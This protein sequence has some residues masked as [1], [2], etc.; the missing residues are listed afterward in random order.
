[1]P[2]ASLPLLIFATFDLALQHFPNEGCAALPP[3][4]LVNPLTETLGQSDVRRFHVERWPSHTCVVTARDT[5]SIR[6]RI[7][8]AGY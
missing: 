3:Y 8:G 1:M 2:L 5:R 7:T 4:Q 6:T